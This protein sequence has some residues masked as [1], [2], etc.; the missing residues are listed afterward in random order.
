MLVFYIIYLVGKDGKNYESPHL[1]EQDMEKLQALF[2][3]NSFW[4]CERSN[5]GNQYYPTQDEAAVLYLSMVKHYVEHDISDET[6]ETDEVADTILVSS[7][8]SVFDNMLAFFEECGFKKTPEE[9]AIIGKKQEAHRLIVEKRKETFIA[10]VDLFFSQFPS[11][12]PVS[13]KALR[14]FLQEK[15]QEY[16]KRKERHGDLRHP[17]HSML[18]DAAYRDSVYKI[19]AAKA[20]LDLKGSERLSPRDMALA[21]LEHHPE[22]FDPHKYL[23]A[24]SVVTHYVG[25]KLFPE[26]R[27]EKSGQQIAA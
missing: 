6:Y 16:K 19:E 20:I 14:S 17:K 22:G 24:L 5:P 1:A 18:F 27:I 26:S 12:T 7:L 9:A 3:E 4:K 2:P 11:I 13:D 21:T 15:C 23:S 25:Q 10:S 8:L